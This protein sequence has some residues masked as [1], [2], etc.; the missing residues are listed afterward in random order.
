M[1]PDL[2]RL[3]LSLD[4]V[5]RDAITQLARSLH[6]NIATVARLL[7]VEALTTRGLLGVGAADPRAASIAKRA[8]PRRRSDTS[9]TSDE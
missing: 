1:P 4:P 7:L 3:T 9:K 2:Y 8:R 6:L 5:L